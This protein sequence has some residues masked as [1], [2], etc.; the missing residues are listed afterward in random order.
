MIAVDT[1][2]CTIC[3]ATKPLTE[4]YMDR[5]RPMA[6]C[7]ECHRGRAHAYRLDNLEAAEVMVIRSQPCA[8][9]GKD[10]PSELDHIIPITRGG[11]H[12]IGNLQPLCRSCNARK[13]NKLVIELKKGA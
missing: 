1:K 3:E 8:H 9:C 13:S 2:T 6:R 11:Q 12:R 4:F 7:K 10:G 5:G